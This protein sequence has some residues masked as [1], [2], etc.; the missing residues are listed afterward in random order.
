[1]R[2]VHAGAVDHVIFVCLL[3]FR[4]FGEMLL[5][6]PDAIRIREKDQAA[7]VVPAH[8]PLRP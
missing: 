7:A 3:H 1:M 6:D 8:L 4:I 2:R 5:Q